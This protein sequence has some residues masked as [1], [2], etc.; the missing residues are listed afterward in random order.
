MIVH[1]PHSVRVYVR[2]RRI[3][4]GFTGTVMAAVGALLIWHDRRD[5]PFSF[6]DDRTRRAR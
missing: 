3:H 5:W 6:Y 4:H 2:G 1:G